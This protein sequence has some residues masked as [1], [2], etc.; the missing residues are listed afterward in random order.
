[1]NN[2]SMS[3][4]N[5]WRNKRRTLITVAS[6]FF[7]VLLSTIMSSM[8]DGTYAN[9]IDMMVKISSGYL[10]IQHPE[11][12]DHKS[13][14]NIFEPNDTLIGKI[15]Q[16]EKITHVIKRLESFALLSYGEQTR[17]G[18]VIGIEP[19]KDKETSNLENWLHRGKFLKK[20]DDGILLTK[21]VAKY[22]QAGL[23]DSI[24]LLS[25]GYHGVTAAAVYPVRGILN[26]STPQLNNLGA[27]MDIKAAQSFYSA[28]N[29]VS[30]LM[31]MVDDYT[32][33]KPV[34]RTLE[35]IAGDTHNVLT[36][37][38]LQPE[39][40]QFIESDKA[41]GLVMKGILYM[42]IAFGILGTIIM[43]IAERR[44]EFGV[45]VAVGMQKFKLSLIV[46]YETIFIGLIGVAIGF[47]L[48]IPVI[49][50]LVNNPIKLPPDLAEAYVQYGFEPYMFFGTAPHVF[51]NQV[52]TVFVITCVV[53]LYPLINISKMKVANV[54]HS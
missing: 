27:F 26:F 6:I 13:I 31:I 34:Q 25:Q 12:N 9:M 11:Y 36:W 10:Q 22:L 21:N 20:G 45:M 44:K 47:A 37:R 3:W 51:V 18:A 42:V 14:N 24:V 33:V 38:Q 43:M 17:G 4:R 7:G 23:N 35:D 15:K 54:L 29:R 2:V 46:F 16:E 50:L 49:A 19:E 1:M 39:I 48:S 52:I 28:G 32:D 40:V 8:Q 5:L 53:S 41:G 30:S